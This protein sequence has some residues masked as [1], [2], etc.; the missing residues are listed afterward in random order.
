[1]LLALRKHLGRHLWENIAID[2]DAQVWKGDRKCNKVVWFRFQNI[3]RGNRAQ[4][5][6]GRTGWNLPIR[7]RQFSPLLRLL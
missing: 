4:I 1:M 6:H 2:R 7:R 5:L 3:G